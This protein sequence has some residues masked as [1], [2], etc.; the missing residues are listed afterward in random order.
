MYLDQHKSASLHRRAISM[1]YLCP[2]TKRG[3]GR[4]ALGCLMLW[5]VLVLGA[6]CA[7]IDLQQR[8]RAWFRAQ[9]R[10]GFRN[11]IVLEEL[12]AVLWKARADPRADVGDSDWR[13][14]ISQPQ[15]DVFRL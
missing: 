15:F 1:L 7:A 9:R 10:L 3:A 11:L 6:E 13:Q 5:P 12:V 4:G 8:M 2:R 14:V